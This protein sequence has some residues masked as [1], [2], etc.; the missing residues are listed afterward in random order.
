MI[1]IPVLKLVE[2]WAGKDI[3][4][5]DYFDGFDSLKERASPPK[6]SFYS[7]LSKEHVGDKVWKHFGVRTLGQ[8]DELYRTQRFYY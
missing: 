8:Y 6:K 4:F 1:E 2:I 7:Q 3:Y 5:Y